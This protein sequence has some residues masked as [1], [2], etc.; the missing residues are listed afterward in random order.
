VHH[1]NKHAA[2]DTGVTAEGKK[3]L[4]V[5]SRNYFFSLRGIFFGFASAVA[6]FSHAA[7]ILDQSFTEPADASAFINEAFPWIAQTY[8]ASLSGTLALVNLDVS[9][10]AGF[11]LRVTAR[12]VV[13]GL[14]TATILG[15]ASLS[16]GS[17][18]LSIEV[19]F[20]DP[21][22]QIAGEQ[23]ALVVDYPTQPSPA[24][25]ANR[26]IGASGDPYTLGVSAASVDGIHWLIDGPGVDLHFRT[27][28]NAVPAPAVL[29]LFA[30][31]ALAAL[32]LRRV[33]RGVR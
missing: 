24:G 30:L 21:I 1:P 27:F 5:R 15:E 22:A 4:S 3:R 12:T 9:S 19:R 33:R 18:P 13:D 10:N 2:L 20:A 11:P 17:A 26:W 7:P 29:H 25:L 8:T 6:A 23:Y 14:P 16:A 32:G 31:G 28:V